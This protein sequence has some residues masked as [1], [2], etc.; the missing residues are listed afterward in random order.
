MLSK[1]LRRGQSPK[2]PRLPPLILRGLCSPRANTLHG[3][4]GNPDYPQSSTNRVRKHENNVT[5]S[6]DE[7][8]GS[9][10]LKR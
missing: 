9:I 1:I 10:Y 4:E 6:R 2:P 3:D 7:K 8:T 5:G